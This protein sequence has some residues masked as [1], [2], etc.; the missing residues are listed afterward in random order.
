MRMVCGTEMPRI[1]EFNKSFHKIKVVV[2]IHK[3]VPRGTGF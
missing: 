3:F 1:H 2:G